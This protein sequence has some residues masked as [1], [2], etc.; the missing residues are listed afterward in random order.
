VWTPVVGVDGEFG[1]EIVSPADEI[2]AHRRA[3]LGDLKP[4]QLARF[5]VDP[6]DIDDPTRWRIRF[7]ANGSPTPVHVFHWS[8]PVFMKRT[9]RRL[10]FFLFR[11]E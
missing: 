2:V 11:D 3:P 9:P 5:D 7:F 8:P 10:G 1:L 6:L 4:G